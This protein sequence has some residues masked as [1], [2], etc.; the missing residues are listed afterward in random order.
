MASLTIIPA[1][2][3]PE[4]TER[5]LRVAAYCRVSTEAEEQN[6]SLESQRSYFTSLIQE[7]PNWEFVGLYYERGKSGTSRK[8][9][10]SFNKMI[11]LAEHKEIDLI[12]TKEVSRFGRNVVDTCGI[13]RDLREIGVYIWFTND[14]LNTEYI[15]DMERLTDLAAHAEK[16]SR[17][18]SER[19]KWGQRERMKHGIVFGRDMLGYTVKHGALTVNEDEA[20]IVQLIYRLFLEGDGTYVIARKLREAGYSPKNPDGKA[21]YSNDWSNTVILRILRNEKY[22]G[23]LLQ[24][25]TYTPDPLTHAKKYNRGEED[26][27]YIKDHHEPIIPREM[28]DEVQVE[29]ARRSP[30]QEVKTKHSNRY[31]CSGKVYCGLCG[32]R[33]VSHI[34]HPKT[35]ETPYKA[36]VCYENVNHG[37]LKEVC[38]G[39]GKRQVGCSNESVNNKAL[40]AAVKAI[41]SFVADYREEI[42]KELTEVLSSTEKVKQDNIQEQSLIDE[43]DAINRRKKKLVTMLADNLIEQEE[44]VEA[45]QEIDTRIKA[46][47][48]ELMILR[49]KQPLKNRARSIQDYIDTIDEILSFPESE[50]SECIYKSVTEKIT[51]HP[52]HCL[53]VYLTC[54][55]YP[56]RVH[57]TAKGRGKNYIISID[58]VEPPEARSGTA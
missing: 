42:K 30:N 4:I 14:D 50:D 33:Y 31:W 21:R 13:A 5:H 17:R 45:R 35:Q 7:N 9:R 19:V 12:L 52:G 29:L 3:R 10:P 51:V 48:D 43:M 6:N 15:K 39:D 24:K 16:E 41:V 11:A 34:K 27:I 32:G 8:H 37:R 57:Y 49:C 23:D 58:S 20:P 56:I 46:I 40:Q 55:P 38:C 44:F 1:N 22:C 2:K 28:W 36:W 26:K 25:K 18:T 53:H 54:L 47:Q